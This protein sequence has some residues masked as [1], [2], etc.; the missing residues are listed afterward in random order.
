MT[1]PRST[2]PQ[3]PSV[4]MSSARRAAPPSVSSASPSTPGVLP[5][6]LRTVDDLVAAG[7]V[8]A[9]RR[10]DAEAVAERYAVAITPAMQALI[11]PADPADPIAR[12]FT[13][14]PRELVTRPDERADPIGDDVHSPTEGLVHRYPDRALLKL[15]HVCAVYCRFCFRRETVGPAGS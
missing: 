13:P 10:P 14:D 1:A 15:V 5:R 7:L 4:P 11:D 2:A 12:Q 9:D 3:P 6:T 8:P